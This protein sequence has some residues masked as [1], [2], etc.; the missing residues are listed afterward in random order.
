MASK[1]DGIL[2]MG[3]PTISVDNLPLIFD[4][5][6]K[7][8]QVDGNSFSFYLTKTAG[9]DGSALVLGGVN[10]K[11]A[12]G[13]WKYYDLLSKDY[14]RISMSDVVFNN[15]SFKNSSNVQAII[16]TGTSVIAGPNKIV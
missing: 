9:Q 13:D 7:Q 16:D 14:W 1:F 4:L 5:L 11:Y 12:A 10:S 3:W 8:G 2:G 6:Y 15:T